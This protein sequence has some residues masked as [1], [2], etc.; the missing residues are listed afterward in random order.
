M[1]TFILVKRNGETIWTLIYPGRIIEDEFW[2][3][4]E[5]KRVESCSVK[6]ITGKHF[7]GDYFWTIEI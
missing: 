7:E 5:V 3:V 4:R 1:D 6:R 2:A